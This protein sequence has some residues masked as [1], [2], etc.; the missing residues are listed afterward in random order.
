MD[1]ILKKLQ[2]EELEILIRID[3][4]CRQ[5]KIKYSLYAGT[6]LGAV[7]HGGFIP[8]DDDIDIAMTRGE[9]DR[10]C[11]IWKKNPV[12]GYYLDSILTNDLCGTCHAKLR[13]DDTL[14]LSKGEIESSGHHGIWVDIFPL[15]VVPVSGSIRRKTLNTGRAIILFTRANADST[16]DGFLKKIARRVLRLFKPK[17]RIRKIHEWHRWLADNASIAESV[18]HEWKCMSS[19]NRMKAITFGADLTS[20]YTTIEF[21]HIPFQIFEDYDGMLR[22]C[23]GDYMTLPPESERI[24]KHLPVKVKFAGSETIRQL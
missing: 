18:K 15:D 22:S 4:F 12:A 16:N 7:R 14:F 21:E 10:F 23:F 3:E 19:F 1:D 2:E 9:F 17:T 8:W 5:N 11:A 13:K 6:A 20:G 24:C